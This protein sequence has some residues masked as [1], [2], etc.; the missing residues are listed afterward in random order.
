MSATSFIQGAVAALNYKLSNEENA[1]R[2]VRA[3][4][5]SKFKPSVIAASE[6]NI[7]GIKA[8]IASLL[9]QIGHIPKI[10]I[11][12]TS[13]EVIVM[14]KFPSMEKARF[15]LIEHRIYEIEFPQ[16]PDVTRMR[17]N[18]AKTYDA[19][20]IDWAEKNPNALILPQVI[21]MFTPDYAPLSIAMEGK[22][23]IDNVGKFFQAGQF[24]VTRYQLRDGRV[25]EATCDT[26]GV[27]IYAA[28]PSREH[29]DNY[30]QP[31]S[32]KEFW[33]EW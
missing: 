21:P 28:F 18:K 15:V 16:M 10:E 20:L 27:W 4:P 26:R 14:A 5:P 32:W 24:P 13:Y 19:Y 17:G 6:K 8:E 23:K 33:N 29:A 11:L 3:R 1:I 9:S 31:Q 12:G 30:K 2:D 7:E 22:E 25:I